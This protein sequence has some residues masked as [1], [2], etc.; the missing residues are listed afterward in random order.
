MSR[1]FIPFQYP[2][3]ESVFIERPN[4]FLIRCQLHDGYGN[5]KIVE[6]H[7]P[8][9]GR[10]KELLI[11]G[12]KV[13]L[14]PVDKPDRK[15][16]WSAALVETPNELGLVSINSTLPNRLVEKAIKNKAIPE[17]EDWQ[18]VRREYTFKGSR[19]DFLLQK[20]E[21]HLALE[22]KGVT[23]IEDNIGYFPDAVTIRGARHVQELA[24]IVKEDNWEAALLFIVQR[25]DVQAIKPCEKIDPNFAHQLKQA[26][27]AGVNLLGRKCH[28]ML[29]GVLL[30]E[31]VPVEV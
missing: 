22:V 4:R 1:I 31:A 19:W 6:A 12:R 29:D 2:L 13:W 10:L 28:I 21:R 24:S 26:K 20:N 7:L 18:Y 25:E 9:S 23:L 8:D 15:T 11:K 5:P 16:R 17:L 3:Q 14:Q 27:S 30:G